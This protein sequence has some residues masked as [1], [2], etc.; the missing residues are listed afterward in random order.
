[1]NQQ[2]K[3]NK[4]QW[5]GSRAVVWKLFETCVRR[6]WWRISSR[7]WLPAAF[8]LWTT[9]ITAIPNPILTHVIL[10]NN[11]DVSLSLLFALS[12]TPLSLFL[13]LISLFSF[14]LS[15]PS[16]I[17]LSGW[18]KGVQAAQHRICHVPSQ[19]PLQAQ[20]HGQ[21]SWCQLFHSYTDALL[22]SL[23]LC[24]TLSSP[25]SLFSSPLLSS[26]LLSPLLSSPR[27]STLLIL[28][29]SLFVSFL[30]PTFSPHPI[31]VLSPS[32]VSFSSPW[33]YLSAIRLSGRCRS[34]LWALGFSAVKT[35][36][37]LSVARC[38]LK[39]WGGHCSLEA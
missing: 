15:L 19:C 12:L 1:M 25:L 18:R 10:L 2:N 21:S 20:V 3:L 37:S 7:L 17:S 38:Y 36:K 4:T 34:W 5:V 32:V 6:G 23:G 30:I 29:L 16:S 28:P 33:R 35:L 14:S 27:Y 26:P 39:H 24:V 11:N 8:D 31:L 13:L 9:E 22:H